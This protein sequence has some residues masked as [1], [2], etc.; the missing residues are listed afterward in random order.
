M[1]DCP[2]IINLQ[3][4]GKLVAEQMDAILCYNVTKLRLISSDFIRKQVQYVS[5][6]VVYG[7]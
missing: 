3:Q 6:I 4:S 5:E 1:P 2:S 7:L